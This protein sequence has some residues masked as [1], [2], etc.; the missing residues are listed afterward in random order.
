MWFSF[1]RRLSLYLEGALPCMNTSD[2]AVQYLTLLKR[3]LVSANSSGH[4]LWRVR[5]RSL[6]LRIL[7]RVAAIKQTFSAVILMCS[8]LKGGPGIRSR[9]QRS[10]VWLL[11]RSTWMGMKE[12]AILS[13]TFIQNVDERICYCRGLSGQR[14]P[15]GSA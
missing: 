13:R 14:L 6:P 9:P 1:P 8:C 2:V 4:E 11:F 5:P 10:I 12:C 3:M 7:E 15:E